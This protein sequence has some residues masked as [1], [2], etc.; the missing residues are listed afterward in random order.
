MDDTARHEVGM[1]VRRQVLGDAHVDRATVASTPFTASFQDF[2]TRYAWG[3]VWARDELDRRTRSCM[4]LALLAA[5][6]H[7]HELAMHV[8]AAIRNGVTP[9][10]IS[11]VLLHVGV[12]AGL[13]AA[14]QAYAIAQDVLVADGHLN[15]PA[16]SE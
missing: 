13:P 4:T 8:R 2:I 12:Y 1:A 10:E 3:E 14:N 15:E 7:H 9:D 5:L 6:N 16:D 11:E